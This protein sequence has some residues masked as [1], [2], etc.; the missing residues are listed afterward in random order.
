MDPPTTPRKLSDH[1]AR[2]MLAERRELGIDE[3]PHNRSSA[4]PRARTYSSKSTIALRHSRRTLPSTRTQPPELCTDGGRTVRTSKQADT[5]NAAGPP[6]GRRLATAP[7]RSIQAMIAR[8]SSWRVSQHR[9]SRTFVLRQG[10]DLTRWLA[11]ARWRAPTFSASR[12]PPGC[13]ERRRGT[14]LRPGDARA[15]ALL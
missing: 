1:L 6:I 5:G 7:V 13:L 9:R 3:R 4:F 12:C 14:G 11:T 8:R 2:Y 10:E 15:H